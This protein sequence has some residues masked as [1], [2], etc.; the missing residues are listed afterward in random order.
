MA[1]GLFAV[2]TILRFRTRNFSLKDMSYIFTTIG[3]SVINSKAGRVSCTGCN[4]LQHNNRYFSDSP[5]GIRIKEQYCYIYDCFSGP[6]IT[7]NS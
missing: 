1:I 4:Y 2:F 3:I 5:R 6:G 7:Q